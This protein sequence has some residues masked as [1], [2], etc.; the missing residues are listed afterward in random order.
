MTVII[1]LAAFALALGILEIFVLPGFGIAGIGSIACAVIDVVLIY[2]SYGFASAVVC[3]V[4][5]LILL[6]FALWW[7][8]HSKTLDK[9]SLHSTISSSNATE[10][11][12][13]VRI[14][15][16]GTA[17]TRL[18]L[19]GNALINGKQVEVK[20]SGAFINPGTPIRVTQVSEANITVEAI[21][22]AG[23]ER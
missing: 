10:A 8:A 15:D 22:S 20:S 3:T 17:V 16:E 4:V 19:I 21:E 5:G 13:S 18:A 9:L 1:I 11:Q 6:V 12:L 23:G 2:N 14:G 7:V